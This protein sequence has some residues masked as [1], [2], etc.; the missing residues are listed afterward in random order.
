[1]SNNNANPQMVILGRETRA[2]T[3]GQLAL[4]V[5]ET[6]ATVS[7]QESALLPITEPATEK[8]AR[9]LEFE[10]D[11]FYQ[12]VPILRLGSTFLFHRKRALVP[13]KLQRRLQ[14]EINIR[15][16]QV[17]RLLKS[18]E[19]KNEHFFP[20]VA[21]DEFRGRSEPVAAFLRDYWRV[22]TGPI[23][24]L[25]QLVE[26]FGGIVIRM[27]FGTTLIDATHVWEPGSPPLFF[28]NSCLPGDRY[29]FTLAH[30][31]GHAVMHHVK[32]TV[33]P[34]TDA[35]QFA[36]AFL[37]PRKDIR[38]DVLG[39]KMEGALNLK[40]VWGVSMQAIIRRGK[41]LEQ[42]TDSTY[43]RMMTALS[44]GG[45]R[46]EEPMPLPI[47]IPT[48]L[49]TILDHHRVELGFS[50]VDM[51]RLMFTSH[52]GQIPAKEQPRMRLVG[53]FDAPDDPT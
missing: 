20:T 53:L 7:K 29:R 24:N 12:Q 47:E 48:A 30:E 13:A 15:R 52:L 39:L 50:D 16:M 28:I 51:R 33:D 10:L 26:H 38:R 23:S 6:Q 42:I 2:W 45:A 3:Q 31:I 46:V 40:R 1:L 43:R 14:A 27:D 5:G 8:F 21:I 18:V 36:A 25:T 32:L 9:A 35:D 41:D 44:A 49:T 17:G 34:E 4:A 37:M 11:F 19:Q 22:P